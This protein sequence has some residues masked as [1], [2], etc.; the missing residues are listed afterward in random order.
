MMT[1]IKKLG[2]ESRVAHRY[3]ESKL[4]KRLKIFAVIISIIIIIVIHNIFVN[5][6]N[7]FLVFSGF[8]AGSLIGLIA[9]RMF[10]IFWHVETQKVVSRLDKIGV[11]FLVLYILIEIGRKQFFG[12]WLHGDVLSAFSLAFLSGLLL[13]RLLTMVKNIKKILTEEKITKSEK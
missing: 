11:I 3:V 13:G 4:L 9:G 1:F 5:N 12:H 10:K 2:N 6:I 8:L 7:P